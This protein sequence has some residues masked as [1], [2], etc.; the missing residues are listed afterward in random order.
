MDD[1]HWLDAASAAIIE[2]AIGDLHG[3]PLGW[4]LVHRPGWTPPVTWPVDAR[5]TL[6]PLGSDTSASYCSSSFVVIA[7]PSPVVICLFG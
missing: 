6:Q 3:S 1:C 5:V 2:E 4:L 7:P